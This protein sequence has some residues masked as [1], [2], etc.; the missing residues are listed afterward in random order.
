M[1]AEATIG[2]WLLWAAVL[3]VAMAL[4]ALYAAA[5]LSIY[6]VNKLRLDLR[7]E[8]GEKTARRLRGM[9]SDFN[10]LLAVLLTGSNFSN[11]FA[12]FAISTMFIMSGAGENAE[13]YTLALATPLLFVLAESVPKS[14]SQHMGDVLAYRLAGLLWAT[15]WVC[16]AIGVAPLVRAI[17]SATTRA[18]QRRRGAAASPLG[19]EGFAAIMAEGQASG[20]LTHFQSV[21]ADRVMHVANVR[22]GDVM[23]PMEKVACIGPDATGQ[24]MLAMV[25]EHNYSRFPVRAADGSIVGVLHIH[26]LLAG[27]EAP[28]PSKLPAPL[29]LP[30]FMTVPDGLYHMQVSAARLAVVTDDRA[31]PMGIVTIKDLVEEIVGEIEE[32]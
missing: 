7:A 12:T 16:T 22:L 30:F 1:I 18:V 9:L 21:M 32:W 17:A 14:V 20:V 15:R 3:V 11:Y 4:S 23:I 10:G 27:D 6:V 24:Q 19:H 28:D 8:A 5:E 13:W 29:K 31:R 26:D 25:K 2:Q